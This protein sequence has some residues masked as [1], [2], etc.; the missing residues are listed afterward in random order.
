MKENKPQHWLSF[1]TG[2]GTYQEPKFE[3]DAERIQEYYRE[4]GYITPASARRS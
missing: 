4:Q 2:R 1:I 3:E